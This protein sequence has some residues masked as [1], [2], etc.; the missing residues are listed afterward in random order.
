MTRDFVQQPSH[1]GRTT[2]IDQISSPSYSSIDSPTN[3]GSV[4]ISGSLDGMGFGVNSTLSEDGFG[5]WQFISNPQP[6]NLSPRIDDRLSR[7]FS[8]T[9]LTT[10]ESSYSADNNFMSFTS[11]HASPSGW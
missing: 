8:P 7:D 2:S 11:Q 4:D 1:V 5:S 10:H 3:D 9:A 6:E